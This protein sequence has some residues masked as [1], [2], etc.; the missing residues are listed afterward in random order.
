MDSSVKFSMLNEEKR[1]KTKAQL[2]EYLAVECERYPLHGRRYISYL[3]Q[4]SEGAILRR[5]TVLLRKTEYFINSGRRV[6][7]FIYHARL[8]RFQ[9]KHFL[10]IP[11]NAFGKGLV[12]YHVAPLVMNDK[13]KVGENCQIMPFVKLVGDNKFDKA[14]TIGNNVTLGIDCTIVGDVYIADGI[15]V[16]AGAIVTKSFYEPEIHIAGV[17]AKIIGTCK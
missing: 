10:H 3:L 17:P 9:N 11:L 15:T 8:M 13:I 7:A 6:R 4:I 14:P 2:K 16:G 5:H 12:I 1:I